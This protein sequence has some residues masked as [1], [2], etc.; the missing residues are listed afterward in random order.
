MQAVPEV[1]A[2]VQLTVTEADTAAA[3]GSGDLAVLGTPRALALCEAATVAAIAPQLS[4]GTTT[5]GT[6]VV[7]HHLRATPVGSQILATA[8][9]KLRDGGRYDFDV[10]VYDHDLLVATGTVTRVAVERKAFL[11]NVQRKAGA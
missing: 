7:L 2:E 6:K 4:S 1:W 10:A 3:L 11:A 9:L 8:T 5:V